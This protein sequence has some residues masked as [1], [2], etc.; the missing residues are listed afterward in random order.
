M[1][2][3]GMLVLALLTMG[4]GLGAQWLVEANVA[5]TWFGGASVDT[6]AGGERLSFRPWRPT[7]FGLRLERRVAKAGIA[8]QLTYAPAALALAGENAVVTINDFLTLYEAALDFSWRIAQ[9][10]TGAGVRA[11]AGP[12]LD[13]WTVSGEDGPRARWGALAAL[14]VEFPLGRR[15]AGSVRAG[16]A[17]T[18]SVF[19]PGELPPEFVRR[20][21]RRGS[22]S[23][24]IRYRV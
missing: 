15:F 3:D 22:V 14:T 13:L 2:R 6:S 19:E 24:G 7:S 5:T 20:A 21:M 12:V 17:L 8:L 9:T 1:R 11:H 16:G 18:P 23:L 4:P 10:G